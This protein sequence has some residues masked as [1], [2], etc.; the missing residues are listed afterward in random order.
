MA[1]KP[2]A[3]ARTYPPKTPAQGEFHGKITRAPG[4]Q[5]IKGGAEDAMR[6]AFGVKPR[7]KC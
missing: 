6:K 7:G 1:K 5:N 4:A 2:A 3:P